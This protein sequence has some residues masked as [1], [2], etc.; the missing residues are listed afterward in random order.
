[1]RAYTTPQVSFSAPVPAVD[2]G[3]SFSSFAPALAK[4]STLR[5]V[6]VSYLGIVYAGNY[7]P[8]HFKTVSSNPNL[9]EIIV[10]VERLGQWQEPTWKSK[11][12]PHAQR[13]LRQ[14][15]ISKD[16]PNSRCVSPEGFFVAFLLG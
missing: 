11:L 2:D 10:R 13:I 4:L 1:M 14:E 5:L 9:V 3:P 8:E 15:E 6:E 7:C 16:L 12:S